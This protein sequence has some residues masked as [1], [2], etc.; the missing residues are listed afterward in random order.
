M[1]E[2]E[3]RCTANHAEDGGR[4]RNKVSL[5]FVRPYY[6]SW[7]RLVFSPRIPSRDDEQLITESEQQ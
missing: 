5:S 1:G 6:L 4:A 7:Y 2:V 3:S